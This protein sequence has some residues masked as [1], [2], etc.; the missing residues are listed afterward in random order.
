MTPV[1]LAEFA[2]KVVYGLFYT[3]VSGSCRGSSPTA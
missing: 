1:L 2:L 3:C